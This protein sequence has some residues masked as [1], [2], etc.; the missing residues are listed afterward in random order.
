MRKLYLTLL[1][2]DGLS[3]VVKN[4]DKHSRMIEAQCE[5]IIET[6]L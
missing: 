2:G 5:Q 1:K 4:L 3:H 6:H